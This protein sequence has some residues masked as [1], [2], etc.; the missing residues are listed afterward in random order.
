MLFNM[1]HCQK[2]PKILINTVDKIQQKKIDLCSTTTPRV[3]KERDSAKKK[4][5]I[6][7]NVIFVHIIEVYSAAIIFH[8]KDKQSFRRKSTKKLEAIIFSCL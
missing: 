7:Y 3:L 8:K 5:F 1:I 6:Y 2:M 4:R